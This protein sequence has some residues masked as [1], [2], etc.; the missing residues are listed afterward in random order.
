MS[1]IISASPRPV[2]Q[3]SYAFQAA[4]FLGF[5]GLVIAFLPGLKE[6][7]ETWNT[8]EEYSYGWFI[9]PI[10]VFLVWQKSDQLRKLELRGSSSGLFVLAFAALMCAAGHV[11]LVRLFLQY[12]F[13]LG[14]FGLV[15]CATGKAGLRLI[16]VP[17]CAMFLMVPLPHLVLHDLS[18]Q[19]Q[20][21][22][23]GIGVALIRMFGIS[24]YLEGNV[25]DLGTYKLQV[26]D[27]CSGLR[28]LFPLIA[29][30]F[31]AAYFFKAALWKRILLLASTVPLTILINSLR[32]AI[33]GFTVEYWG[34]AM[35]DG[36][37]HEFEGWFMFMICLALIVVEMAIL[38][39]IGGRRE[40]LRKTFGFEFPEKKS[41]DAKVSLRQPSM[42]LKAGVIVCVAL[43]A[44]VALSPTK[45]EIV[46][47]RQAFSTFPLKLDG[48][49]I[50][51]NARL[52]EDVV[53]AL[54]LDDYLLANYVDA[55]GHPLNFYVAYYA[56]QT[57]AEKASHSP[58]LCIP[59]GGWQ[60]NDLRVVN[61]TLANGKVIPVNRTI[62]SRDG[63]R[64]LVYYWFKQS[65]RNV[66]DDWLIKGYI[67]EDSVLTGKTDGALVRVVAPIANDETPEEVDK[68][69]TAFVRLIEPRLSAYVPS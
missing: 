26:V 13:M 5:A 43:A 3:N 39:R 69:M 27:A 24:V 47:Q 31:L 16:A 68:R 32:I 11:S 59:G 23:S 35:A 56:T 30:G 6:M 58:R 54:E 57:G 25:I 36:F 1:A 37:L 19:L 38:A 20:L 41:R 49:W 21:L 50:G 63:Q 44:A 12:G 15:L 55:L 51:R 17:L 40:S 67:I 9:P 18:E 48:G 33:V 42:P 28:Y 7:V 34:G 4:F 66:T 60:L 2:W 10:V 14:I 52:D 53:A 62:I 64:Q 65:G 29:M 22:S 45:A 46:P 61:L 8:V